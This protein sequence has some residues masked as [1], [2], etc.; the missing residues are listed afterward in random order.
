[1]NTEQFSKVQRGAGFIAAL[2]QSGGSTPKALKL[3]GIDE[4]AYSGDAQ[5]FDLV[6]E[7]RTRIITSPSFD[8]DRILGAILFEDTM[9]RDVDGRPT[10]DYLWNVKKVV[11]FLKV[12]KGLADE[13]DGA[14]VMKPIP[15]LDDL[16]S[17]A[18]DKGV[19]G[20]KMR[21]VI[22]APGAGLQAVV[23]Q[24]FEIGKQILA[25]GLVPIIEPEVDIH[26]PQ[27]AEA[28]DQLKAALLAALDALDEGQSVMLKLTL[29]TTDDLYRELVD[30]PK[31][32]RVVALSGGYDRDQACD[33]L[34]ANHGVI[35][36]F[37][38]ALTEGLTAQQSDEEFNAT[39]DAAITAIAKAS[40]T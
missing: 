8:G 19:F 37:S 4:D 7:M 32:V 15:G 39:L 12:D 11:P 25:A 35:A 3:Y 34:A 10:A 22:K 17:R 27:K 21:S 5:M 28:E 9:D 31:V 14:Q 40:A 29:P 16:L 20:T 6:H 1:M 23:D 2:D 30:H 13:Q 36:S 24:Q 18:R 33:K 38:R 26:S